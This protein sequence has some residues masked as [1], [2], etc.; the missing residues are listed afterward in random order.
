LNTFIAMNIAHKICSATY[1]R[2]A[3]I[4]LS[5]FAATLSIPAQANDIAAG[6]EK[7]LSCAMCHGANGISQMPSAPHLAGQP[8]IYLAE[9]L[10]NF[11]SGK[12]SNE[13]MNVIAKPLSDPEIS[14]LAAWFESIQIEVRAR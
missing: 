11:R 6:R 14:D 8:A 13:I 9:Q 12:R 10:K 7:A 1:R 3:W 5:L 2:A 4:A